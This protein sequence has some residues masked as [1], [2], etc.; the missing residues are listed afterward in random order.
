MALHWEVYPCTRETEKWAVLTCLGRL[1][2]P[3]AVARTVGKF[4]LIGSERGCL[5]RIGTGRAPKVVSETDKMSV[6][7]Y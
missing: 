1:H 3:G 2:A 4:L 6:F 7:C 5:Y